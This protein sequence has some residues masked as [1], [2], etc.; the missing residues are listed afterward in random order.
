MWRKIPTLLQ[1]Y[2][3]RV[4]GWNS[5]LKW[6]LGSP[7]GL[8]KLQSSIA[9]VKTPRIRVFFIWLENY[10]SLDVENGLT[11]AIWTS[12]TH[13]ME[14]KKGRELNWQFDFR[15]LKVG[16]RHDPGACRW[17]VIHRWKDF[18][19]SYKFPS[20]LISIGGMSKKL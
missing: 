3:E 2:F 4:W 8:S 14:K 1:P 17:S 5:L 19:E 13:V 10:R 16:N 12:S 9:E 15:P 20:N 11:W 6:G 18:K 7:P